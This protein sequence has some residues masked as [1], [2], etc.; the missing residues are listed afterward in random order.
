M[1]SSLIIK[2]S[3]FSFAL[4]ASSV[5]FKRSSKFLF[6]KSLSDEELLSAERV[7]VLFLLLPFESCCVLFNEFVSMTE[8]FSNQP[9]R[10][11]KFMG[12]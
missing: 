2:S 12:I 6:R 1:S 7:S 8:T 10:S 4:S 5:K 11:K 9:D 3:S